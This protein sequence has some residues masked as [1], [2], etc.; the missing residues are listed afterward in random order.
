MYMKFH[1]LDIEFMPDKGLRGDRYDYINLTLCQFED[2][3]DYTYT[4]FSIGW[5]E[6]DFFFDI[7]FSDFIQR[8]IEEWKD[9]RSCR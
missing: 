9:E 1:L 2:F 8:K 7:L 5:W 4:L 6:G 3:N